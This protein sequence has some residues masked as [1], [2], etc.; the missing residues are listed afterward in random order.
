MFIYIKQVN[1]LT[2]FVPFNKSEGR[3]ERGVAEAEVEVRREELEVRR[4][5]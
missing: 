5:R 1:V 3:N 2:D 4:R